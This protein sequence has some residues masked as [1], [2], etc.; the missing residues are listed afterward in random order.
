MNNCKDCREWRDMYIALLEHH[1]QAVKQA[2]LDL[3]TMERLEKVR[4]GEERR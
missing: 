4:E 2:F 1:L 3:D